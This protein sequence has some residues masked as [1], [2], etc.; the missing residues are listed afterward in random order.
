M[1]DLSAQVHVAFLFT[2]NDLGR[3]LGTCWQRIYVSWMPAIVL[4]ETTILL[5]RNYAIRRKILLWRKPM[6]MKPVSATECTCN[7]CGAEFYAGHTNPKRVD[8]YLWPAYCPMCGV[9]SLNRDD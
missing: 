4:H 5:P 9:R 2:S 7:H 6:F 3:F 8:D 1:R